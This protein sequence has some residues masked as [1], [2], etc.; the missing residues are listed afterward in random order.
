MFSNYSS[1][2]NRVIPPIIGKHYIAP[3]T[4]GLDRVLRHCLDANHSQRIES[5]RD[6]ERALG[7][8]RLPATTGTIAASSRWLGELGATSSNIRSGNS[9]FVAECDRGSLELHL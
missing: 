4:Q 8:C 6:L 3:Q 9:L 7:L 5:G 2:V 1:C